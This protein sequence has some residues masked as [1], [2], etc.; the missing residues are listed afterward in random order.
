MGVI[1]RKRLSLAD[2]DIDSDSDG[3]KSR[4]RLTSVGPSRLEFGTQ[5]TD[6]LDRFSYLM[7]GP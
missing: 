3:H 2:D 4:V 7:L 5:W 6:A 1:K